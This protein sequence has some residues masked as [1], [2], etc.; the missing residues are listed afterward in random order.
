MTRTLCGAAFL[1]C[2]LTGH[3]ATP[4]AMNRFPITDFGAV[5]DGTTMNIAAIQNAID[6]AA[7]AGGGT[8]VI[9]SGTFASGAIFLKQG[10][11]L[12]LDE[13]AGLF[14]SNHIEDYP[15]RQTR[16][17]GHFGPWRLALV[18]AQQIN[19]VRIGGT[20]RLTGTA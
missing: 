7:A 15:K 2:L 5:A 18:N 19:G 20:G 8:V 9:P 13:G 1:V 6:T 11:A 12:W 10:V 17:E 3:A 16:I 4:P 14:G